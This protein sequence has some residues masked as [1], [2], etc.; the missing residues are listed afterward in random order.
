VAAVV[1][2]HAHKGAPEGRTTTGV[3]VYNVSLPLMRTAYPGNPPFRLLE[4]PLNPDGV[5]ADAQASPMHVQA[6]DPS[7][8]QAPVETKVR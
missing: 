3:P 5:S 2:G 4:V 1:H 8:G 6:N 7:L